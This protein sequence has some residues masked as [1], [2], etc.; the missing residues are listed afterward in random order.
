[1]PDVSQCDF[2]GKDPSHAGEQEILVSQAQAQNIRTNPYGY[3]PPTR[4]EG[5][6]LT[7]FVPLVHFI[8]SI[9][10]YV[11]ADHLKLWQCHLHSVLSRGPSSWT[12]G[13]KKQEMFRGHDC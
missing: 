7:F 10:I 12:P 11:P 4:T 8:S 2:K 5:R 1:M 13:V 3:A 9:S 6:T